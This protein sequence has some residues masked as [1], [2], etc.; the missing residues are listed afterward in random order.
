MEYRQ[1]SVTDRNVG[2]HENYMGGIDLP[3]N[4]WFVRQMPGDYSFVK[5]LLEGP[6]DVDLLLLVQSRIFPVASGSES[7]LFGVVTEHNDL[8]RL[9]QGDPISSSARATNTVM[10]S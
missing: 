10:Y 3:R 7:S 8:V 2:S 6:D 1:S 9:F 4:D 5:Q